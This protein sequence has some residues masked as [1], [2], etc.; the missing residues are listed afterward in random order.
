MPLNTEIFIIGSQQ[1]FCCSQGLL[2]LATGPFIDKIVGGKWVFFYSPSLFSIN[3]VLLSSL[4]AV[5]VNLSAFFCLGKFSAVTF[6]VTGHV[7][8]LLVLSGGYLLFNEVL[9]AKQCVGMLLAVM[10][11]AMLM[12]MICIGVDV[13][14]FLSVHGQKILDTV[15]RFILLTTDMLVQ[16][17]SLEVLLADLNCLYCRNAFVWVFQVSTRG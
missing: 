5:L 4:V 11:E 7:K 9:I 8:T 1:R 15:C 3:L 13:L 17:I 12:N 14:S 10:G 16:I 2:L 6:Q